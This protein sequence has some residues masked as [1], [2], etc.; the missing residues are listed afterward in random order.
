MTTH[1][2]ESFSKYKITKDLVRNQVLRFIL[3]FICKVVFVY[4]Y[5]GGKR[6]DGLG[7]FRRD[8]V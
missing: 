4:Q 6:M 5:Q 7:W 3:R 1:L 8:A 2:Y